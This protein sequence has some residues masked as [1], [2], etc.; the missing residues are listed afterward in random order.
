M[1]KKSAPTDRIKWD[2]NNYG[3]KP[4]SIGKDEKWG[5]KPTGQF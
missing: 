3:K 5:S 4:A 2:S 1:V